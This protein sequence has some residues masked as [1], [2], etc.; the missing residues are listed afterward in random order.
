M[1]GSTDSGLLWVM[2]LCGF[3]R[4]PCADGVFA[5]LVVMDGEEAYSASATSTFVAAQM[6]LPL[7][8]LP[9]MYKKR[10]REPL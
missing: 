3:E 6:R 4:D 1:S 5:S 8:Q 10:C 9:R 7:I 2:H